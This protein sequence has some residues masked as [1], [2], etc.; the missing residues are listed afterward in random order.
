M[1]VA[2]ILTEA[3]PYI[4]NYIGK[5]IVI[6]YG[7]NAMLSQ[8]LKESIISDIVLLHMIGV[9][10]VLVHGGGPDI[11][12]LLDKL[13]KKSEFI[14]GL[15]Y[16]DDEDIEYIQMVLC[17]KTNKELVSLIGK[18]GGKAVGLSGLDGNMTTASKMEKYGNVGEITHVDPS[19]VED[20][21]QRNYIPVI[22][23]IAFS[24]GGSL[25][26]NADLFAAK[27]SIVLKADHFMLLTDV[28]GVMRDPKDESTLIPTIKVSTVPKLIKEGI[29][30]GGMIPKVDCCTLAVR[31]G[32]KQTTIQ[33]GTQ[34]H[35]ILLELL[36]NEGS[37]TLFY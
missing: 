21:L 3:L 7:G 35:S 6:K 26:V 24:D 27:L 1:E 15:R 16:T 28:K 31:N 11:N 17:G 2:A 13:G 18:A 25:N 8:E 29:I 37:G 36:S 32:V 22:S 5:T 34:K 12:A 10:V 33:K 23:S 19:L 14:D 9:K 4:Q 20:L 30:S